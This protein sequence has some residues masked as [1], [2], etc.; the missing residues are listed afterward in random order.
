M[1]RIYYSAFCLCA[2]IIFSKV[3]TAQHPNWAA[4]MRSDSLSLFEMEQLHNAHWPKRPGQKGQG[5]KQFE[6]FK[7]L[8]EGRLTD[9]GKP[10]SG[11]DVLRQWEELKTFNGNRSIAGNWQSLG[12][13][14]DDVTTRDHIEG[15]GRVSCIAFHPTDANIIFAGAPA[16]GLWRSYDGGSS[17]SSNTDWLPTLGIASIAFNPENPQIVYLGT[18]DYDASDSPG[19]GVMKSEDGGETWEFVNTGIASLM[20]PCIRFEPGSNDLWACTND[21]LYESTDEGATWTMISE[22]SNDFEDLEFH[23]TDANTAYATAQGKLYITHDGG[24]EWDTQSAVVGTGQRMLVE[25]TEAA[26]DVVYILKTGTYEFSGFYKSSD[27]AASFIEM[28]DEPNI[29]GWAADGSSSGGQAWYDLCFE[30][31]NMDSNT[32]YAGGIRLKKSTDA[33][34]TWTDINPN[35][36]HVDQHYLEMNPH[37]HD[38]F[39]CNDGGLYHYVDNTEWLDI[40]KHIVNG[41]IYQLGQSPHNPN[42]TLTG[43]QDNGTAEYD[44]VFWRRRGGG[45]GFECAYDH[46]ETGY[47]YGSIYYGAIY[48][49]T[50]EVVNQKICGDEELGINEEGAWNTPYKLHPADTTGNTLFVGLKNVWRCINIKEPEKDSIDWKRVSNNLGGNNSIDLNEIEISMSNPNIV[51]ATEPSK[52]LFITHNALADSVIWTNLSNSLPSYL[53]AINAIETHP[54]DTNVVYICF[55]NDVYKSLDQGLT[56]ILLSENLPDISTNTMVIDTSSYSNEGLYVGTDM[57][58][59]YIDTTMTEWINFS[60]GLPISSRITELEIFYGSTPSQHRLKASTYGRGLWESDLYS[61]ETNNFPAVA[62]IAASNS[63]TEAFSNFDVNILFYRSLSETDVSGFD[64]LSDI[65]AY[66]AEVMSISGGPSNYT[67]TIQ[68]NIYGEIKLVVPGGA[69]TDVLYGLETFH[70]DTLR[71]YYLPAPSTLGPDGPGGVGEAETVAFWLRADMSA[72]GTQGTVQQ[73]TDV[74]GNNYSA[75][76]ANMS[77]RPALLVNGINGNPALQ[78]D[79]INDYLSL[80]DVVPGRSM[81]AYMMVE[82]DSIGFNQHGWFASAR[83]ENGYLMHP[84]KESTQYHGDVYDLEG[85][86]SGASS[87]Y[88]GDAAAPHIYG[89]IYQQDDYHQT[90]QQ[91]FDD[92]YYPNNGVDLGQRNNTTPIE[93][94]RIG[95]DYEE[96]FGKGRIAEH[97]VYREKLQTS[98]HR[99]VS[100]YMAAKYGIDMGPLTLYNHDAQNQ[101]VIGIGRENEY[102]YHP[103]A[104]GKQNIR[105]MNATNLSDGDYLLIGTDNA[106]MVILPELYPILTPRT[107]RTWAFTETG[108]VGVVTIRIATSEFDNFQ[109]LGIIIMEG[110]EFVTGGTAM[111]YPLLIQGPVLE[112]QIDFPSSGVFT[113]GQQPVVSVANLDYATATIYPNPANE[114]LNVQLHNAWP[115]QWQVEVRNA[116]GQLVHIT[117][118]QGKISTIDVSTFASGIYVVDVRVDGRVVMRQKL[119]IE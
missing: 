7:S 3:S 58:V 84:W 26:P 2:S 98:H 71:M 61:A 18:G 109:D 35:Y 103:V 19:M 72:N 32:V 111:W 116:I 17:W 102:D 78:F 96:R 56:W 51:Y 95:W 68:P 66:N 40:S 81:S 59:Y 73:W 70:S 63:T 13:I 76:Q 12:P 112:A 97:F 57:G 108:D 55:H 93:E 99:I 24:V 88:I 31:D 10:V 80:E 114:V 50:P 29:M 119:M 67:A 75:E 104:Q 39:A 64:A 91:V 106:S 21:G 34:T 107:E 79:G 47:R 94:I 15:V 115:E 36:V 27:M 25:V 41:Q 37:N 42:H 82:T 46:S 22:F 118:T 89:F 110:D 83:S 85:E 43:F 49:T 4:L 117:M 1:N 28:S 8:H 53:V 5:F 69:A 54:T 105:I 33:G 16:G 14:L 6:R 101:E 87:F 65:E 45:D 30:A 77:E 60:E 86:S 44:G 38:L 62:S 100:N 48:R 11:E 23:P 52:K 113:I 20:V 9:I 74:M 92:N 90:M